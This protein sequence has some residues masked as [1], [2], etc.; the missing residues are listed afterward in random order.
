MAGAGIAGSPLL[1][2]VHRHRGL[3]FPLAATSLVLVILIPLPPWL[4]DMLLSTNITLAAVIMLTT[5]YVLHPLDFS[6]F[7]SLLLAM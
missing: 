1:A 3:I 5:I 2:R 7:P 6:V 4:M